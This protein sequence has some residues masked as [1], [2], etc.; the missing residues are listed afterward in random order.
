MDKEYNETYYDTDCGYYLY[1]LRASHGGK[2]T[3]RYMHYEHKL[4]IIYFIHGTG[5][6]KIEGKQYDIDEG[7]MVLVNPNELFQLNVDDDKFH[8]RIILSP[9]ESILKNF[10]IENTG[11]FEGFFK[12]KKAVGNRIPAKIVDKQNIGN[13]LL[14]ILELAKSSDKANTVLCICKIIEFLINLSRKIIPFCNDEGGTV[15]ENKLINDIIKYIKS[16]IKEDIDIEE[17]A[18]SFNVGKSH[19]SH[20][21]KEQVGI[22]IWNYVI[23]RRLQLFNYLIKNNNSIEETCYEVGFKNYS[24]FFRLYKKHMNMTPTEYKRQFIKNEKDYKQK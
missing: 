8:E 1:H 18:D 14:N 15:H 21:F 5:N 3:A 23:I 10:P 7:D 20:L 9:T 4:L 24:N 17:I 16:H 6:I 11:I 22:S 12:R 19:L 13:E 2:S